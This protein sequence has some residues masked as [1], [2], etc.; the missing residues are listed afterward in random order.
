MVENF[1]GGGGYH[2]G[3]SFFSCGWLI[4]PVRFPINLN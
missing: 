2:I 3:V 1:F 4:V